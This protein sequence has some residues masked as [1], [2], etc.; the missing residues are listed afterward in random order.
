MIETNV[1]AHP[2]YNHCPRRMY[3]THPNPVLDVCFVFLPNFRRKTCGRCSTWHSWHRGPWCSPYSH[4]QGRRRRRLP[5][6]HYWLTSILH[7]DIQVARNGHPRTSNRLLSS[8][9]TCHHQ[10]KKH[11]T[12]CKAKTV[13]NIT[14]MVLRQ[15]GAYRLLCFIFGNQILVRA[16]L[17]SHLV[18]LLLKVALFKWCSTE[19]LLVNLR[20]ITGILLCLPWE[21]EYMS[22]HERTLKWHVLSATGECL[23]G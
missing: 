20:Q 7:S 15:Q 19:H 6:W 23:K 11:S 16:H 1:H 21:I 22:I 4:R 2:T 13:S 5:R 18:E 8:W 14:G 12:K 3:L 9:Q 10:R 17:L